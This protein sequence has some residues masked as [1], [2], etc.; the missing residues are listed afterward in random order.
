MAPTNKKMNKSWCLIDHTGA[1]GIL[2]FERKRKDQRLR[3]QG[4][5]ALY[6]IFRWALG[7]NV[8]LRVRSLAFPL[9]Q[10]SLILSCG[11]ASLLADFLFI[12]P[13]FGMEICTSLRSPMAGRYLPNAFTVDRLLVLQWQPATAY[14]LEI[15]SKAGC[16][17]WL[18]VC[19]S[20]RFGL[21]LYSEKQE[22]PSGHY[23]PR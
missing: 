4:S 16:S 18:L 7:T 17:S 15:F 19:D 8:F 14:V 13:S 6:F 2:I 5:K 21:V 23:R 12:I 11:N 9:S 10:I 3:S 20:C 22:S 1:A